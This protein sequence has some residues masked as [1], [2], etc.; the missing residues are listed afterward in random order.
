MKDRRKQDN[1]LIDI[2]KLSP[3]NKLAVSVNGKEVD[4]KIGDKI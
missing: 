1:D 3:V 4:F 2:S